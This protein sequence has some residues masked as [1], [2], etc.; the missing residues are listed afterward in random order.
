[1]AKSR[2]FQLLC[3]QLAYATLNPDDSEDSEDL[4]NRNLR[5]TIPIVCNLID[6]LYFSLIKKTRVPEGKGR[7][8]GTQ[9]NISLI[10]YI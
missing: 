9:R 10:I 4:S 6:K 1:M 2:T 5:K 8:S 3:K 7:T